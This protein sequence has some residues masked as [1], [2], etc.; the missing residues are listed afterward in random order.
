MIDGHDLEIR[1]MD[2]FKKG[3]ARE[4][5]KLQEK[6][7]EEVKTSGED[8]CS[9]PAACKYHGKCVDCVLIHRGHAD[10]LPHCFQEMVNKRLETLSEL[11]EHSFRNQSEE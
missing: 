4:A 11:T 7:L 2:L 6:F 8:L 3:D 9:C 10:H 1:A 5:G